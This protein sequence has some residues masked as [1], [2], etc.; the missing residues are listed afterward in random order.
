MQRTRLSDRSKELILAMCH[1]YEAG[2]YVDGSFLR[3]H[4]SASETVIF[5]T[6]ATLLRSVCQ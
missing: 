6:M 1:R 2:P 3:E 4:A 5:D